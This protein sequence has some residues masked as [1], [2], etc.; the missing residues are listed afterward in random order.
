MCIHI[1]VYP[2]Q[3][4]KERER[5]SAC[6][7]N[8]ASNRLLVKARRQATTGSG[9]LMDEASDLPATD[10]SADEAFVFFWVGGR[11]GGGV[12]IED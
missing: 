1:Y 12:Q 9:R 7:A 4:G 2:K 11:G 10:S 6:A 8:R 3:T 5:E